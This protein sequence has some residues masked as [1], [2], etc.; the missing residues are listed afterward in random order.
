MAL[1]DC[2]LLCRT[3]AHVL[4]GFGGGRVLEPLAGVSGTASG[5]SIEILLLSHP[6][7]ELRVH[8]FRGFFFFVFTLKYTPH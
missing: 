7:T 1:G 5:D 8:V 6:R 3:S 2:L 4:T